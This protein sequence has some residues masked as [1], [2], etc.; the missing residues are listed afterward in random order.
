MFDCACHCASGCKCVC[1]SVSVCVSVCVC[2]C[3]SLCVCVCECLGLC[4]LC[5]RYDGHTL[6]MKW[7]ALNIS[8][9]FNQPPS[10]P[11]PHT[12]TQRHTLTL[13]A[14]PIHTHTY[15]H[16]L[17]HT[18][19]Q[20]NNHTDTH[21]HTH[22]RTPHD[23]YSKCVQ[24]FI[25]AVDILFKFEGSVRQPRPSKP[26]PFTTLSPETPSI[27]SPVPLHFYPDRL[28]EGHVPLKGPL[29]RALGIFNLK[30]SL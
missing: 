10:D 14:P 12:L 3:V 25:P 5:L 22:S 23:R 15:T 24:Y 8:Q 20:R 18:Q 21:T 7:H 4:V 30:R 27:H 16:T 13:S 19:T 11:H 28:K 2:V 1:V 17:R 6:D 9:G 26:T 29:R